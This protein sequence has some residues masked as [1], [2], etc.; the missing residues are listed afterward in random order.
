MARSMSEGLPTSAATAL[1]DK[2]GEAHSTDCRKNAGDVAGLKRYAT[3]V[4][5][6]AIDLISSSHFPPIDGSKLVKPVRL[7]P[8]LARV[9]TNLATTGSLTCTKTIGIEP[10]TTSF[11]AT[12]IGVDWTN[13]RS[14]FRSISSFVN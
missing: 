13:I 12:V 6:G 2:I 10:A 3:L 8:G 4:T 14:G 5:F 11:A 7:P 9:S 1:S